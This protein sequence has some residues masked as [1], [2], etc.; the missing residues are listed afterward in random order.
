MVIKH[1]LPREV[2]QKIEPITEQKCVCMCV[3][4]SLFDAEGDELAALQC[5][6]IM[7]QCL[8]SAVC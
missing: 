6:L 5:S 2:M 3:C 4:A 7:L 1:L 8:P